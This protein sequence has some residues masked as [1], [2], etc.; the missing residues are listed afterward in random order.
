MN[1]TP[2]APPRRL[3]PAC[4]AAA[5]IEEKE[6]FWPS[7]W[8]CESCGFSPPSAHGF[9]LLAPEY[10][11][12]HEGFDLEIFELLRKVEANLF[13][14]VS[15]NELIR[16][17]VDH[18]ARDAHRVLEIGCGTGFVLSA[19]RTALPDAQIA[20]SELHSLGLT[21]ARARHGSAVE[22]IQ[23]DARKTG[24]VDAIDLVGA[25]DVLEHIPEDDA[26][27]REIYRMLKPGGVLI[28][29]VPQHPWMWSTVDDLGRHQRR[30]RIGEL[31]RKASLAGLQPIYRSSFMTL[32]FPLMVASRVMERFRPIS[33]T[34]EEEIKAEFVM[35]P[36]TG[37]VL[38][39]ISRLEHI[40]RKLGAPMPFGGS[41]VLV[42]RRPVS[43]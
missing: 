28:A 8:R 9:I 2:H 39:T 22:L 29:T 34:L 36:T 31:A 21:T 19:L 18:F 33:R 6:R 24:L 23:M 20:G 26:V 1:S 30:Y 16:W 10:D 13:W 40:L 3:C 41:Q 43:Q 15:R 5:P 37:K 35:S 4:G 27:L 14:F 12:V 7:G 11:E 42:G 25:F 32:A 38:L 17:L